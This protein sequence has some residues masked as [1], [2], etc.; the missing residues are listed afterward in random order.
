MN[1]YD[2]VWTALGIIL[3]V[4]VILA[5]FLVGYVVVRRYAEKAQQKRNA[6]WLENYLRETGPARREG[7]S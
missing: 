6:G 7:R 5:L 3:G 2:P 4:L 1:T